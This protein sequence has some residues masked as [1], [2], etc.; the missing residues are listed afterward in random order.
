MVSQEAAPDILNL[1]VTSDDA[2]PKSSV[3]RAQR[4]GYTGPVH[5]AIKKGDKL[6]QTIFR[7]FSPRGMNFLWQQSIPHDASVFAFLARPNG[8][9]ACVECH[10]VHCRPENGSFSIGVE[11]TRILDRGDNATT[12]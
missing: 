4:L 9:Q 12:H 11:F 7:D 2:E 1:I 10:V 8:R 3:R 5:V 6:V